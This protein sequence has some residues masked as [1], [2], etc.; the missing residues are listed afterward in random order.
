MDL[1]SINYQPPPIN[2]CTW[3][4]RAGNSP[5]S[6]VCLAP[7]ARSSG[8]HA[9]LSSRAVACYG[10]S[11]LEQAV[12]DLRRI[13]EWR[14][15]GFGD[16]ATTINNVADRDPGHAKRLRSRRLPSAGTGP[17]VKR[18]GP[19]VLR[20]MIAGCLQ[21]VVNAYGHNLNAVLPC[22]MLFVIFLHFLERLLARA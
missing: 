22:G 21:G 9:R 3:V 16:N 6:S 17:Y 15:P 8:A 10:V 19:T 14:E 7:A 1:K 4:A 11:S 12:H 5:A 18:V 2:L 13:Q 20:Q